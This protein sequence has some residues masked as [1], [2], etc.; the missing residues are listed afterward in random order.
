MVQKK[1]RTHAP[2]N[3]ASATALAWRKSQESGAEQ[4]HARLTLRDG[5]R[6]LVPLD[7]SIAR[8]DE[9]RARACL[10]E[11]RTLLESRD[12]STAEGT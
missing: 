6:P 2:S 3:A 7:P 10:E 1:A 11:I 12:A 9:T 5:S 4:W 8:D